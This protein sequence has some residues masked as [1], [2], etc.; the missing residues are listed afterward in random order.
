MTFSAEPP[1]IDPFVQEVRLLRA[2]GASIEDILVLLRQ[3]GLS[4]IG[5]TRV[6]MEI[7]G[8]SLA[9]AKPVVHLSRAWADTREEAERFHEMLEEAAR[10]IEQDSS[11]LSPGT[12]PADEE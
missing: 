1:N 12:A 8:L 6:L 7:E 9:E 11:F 3:K 4:R 5:S 2:K 10:Q